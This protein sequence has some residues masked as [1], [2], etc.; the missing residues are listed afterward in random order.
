MVENRT[1]GAIIKSKARWAEFGEKN[2]KYFLNL[3]KRNRAKKAINE[4]KIEDSVIKDQK[5]ILN[6]L[7]TYYSN[8]YSSPSRTTCHLKNFSDYVEKAN[9]PKLS[10]DRRT[11]CDAPIAENEFKIALH[12]LKT[13]KSPGLHEFSIKFCK[14]FW[15]DLKQCVLDSVNFSLEHG[16]LGETQFKE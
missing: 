4:L 3:E 11:V 7:V 10:E 15:E 5:L 8:L 1:K 13:N 2:T 9:L 14:V 6:E 12:Q 16:K